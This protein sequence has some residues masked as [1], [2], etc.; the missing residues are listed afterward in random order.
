MN[1]WRVEAWEWGKLWDWVA[2]MYLGFQ[3]KV[4]YGLSFS[5]HWLLPC[6]CVCISP[7]Q[8]L[9]RCIF[10]L[11][12]CDNSS[13]FFIFARFPYSSC[14]PLPISQTPQQ[15]SRCYEKPWLVNS[16]AGTPSRGSEYSDYQIPS[17]EVEYGPPTIEPPPFSRVVFLLTLCLVMFSR[18][19][20]TIVF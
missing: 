7:F 13:P 8:I 18:I 1:N 14:V 9:F 15:P 12:F 16:K 20:L 3:E 17:C 2:K 6:L 4:R 19:E 5:R 10:C 11:H